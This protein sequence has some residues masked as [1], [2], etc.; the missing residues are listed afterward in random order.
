MK[1]IDQMEENIPN[2]FY[3]FHLWALGKLK[4]DIIP[5]CFYSRV[6]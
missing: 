2:Y 5:N 6:S 1:F 3:S 4:S